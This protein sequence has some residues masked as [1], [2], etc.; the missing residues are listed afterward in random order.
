MVTAIH[1]ALYYKS[2]HTDE[3][4]MFED[5]TLVNLQSAWSVSQVAIDLGGVF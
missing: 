1:A 3:W 5:P 2:M 4:R